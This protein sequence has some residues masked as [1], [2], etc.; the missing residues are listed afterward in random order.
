MTRGRAISTSELRCETFASY[1]ASLLV[2]LQHLKVQLK[3]STR[4]FIHPLHHLLLTLLPWLPTARRERII[5]LAVD[6]VS[7][8]M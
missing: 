2:L 7:I 4:E 5:T 3:Q 6:E 8:T 1:T